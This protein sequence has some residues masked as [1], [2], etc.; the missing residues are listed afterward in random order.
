VLNASPVI[1]VLHL[2][3]QANPNRS[4]ENVFAN[5]SLFA[6]RSLNANN[7]DIGLLKQTDLVVIESVER[8]EGAMRTELENFVRKGG[9]ILVVPPSNPDIASYG[10]FLN[11]LGVNSL[12]ERTSNEPIPLTNPERKSPFFSDV[13]E[14]SIRQENLELPVSKPV[15][16]WQ[17]GGAKLLS[18]RSGDVFLSQSAVQRGK[19]YVLANPLTE[20]FGSFAQNALFVPVMYKIAAQSVREQRTAYSFD[21]N[22]IALTVPDLPQNTIFKLKKGKIELIPV[23]RLNGN[24]LT[25]EL[26]KSNQL[27]TEQD[28]ESGYYE[29]QKDGQTV[30]LLALNHDN[31]ESQL[32]YYTPDEL[33]KL[34]AN[35]PNVQVFDHVADGDFVKE[36]QKQNIGVSLWKYFLWA[37]LAF[38]L[39]E[40]LVIRLIK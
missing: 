17:A 16:Q 18:L 3:G 9:S 5:D 22:N 12:S 11:A 13:F 23:Q 31:Q 34:F 36:F 35:Q 28:M 25:L 38:L 26:P 19:V 1:R 33:R 37:A 32:D 30:Q 39:L 14:Q 10:G 7:A 24:Q 15:W 8:V 4:I 20:A 29:L 6:M 2:Y 27:T 40:I 21:E